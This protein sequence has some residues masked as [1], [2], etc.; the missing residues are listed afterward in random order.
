MYFDNNPDGKAQLENQRI[1]QMINDSPLPA[2]DLIKDPEARAAFEESLR[3]LAEDI[4]E[5]NPSLAHILLG[6]GVNDG[7]DPFDSVHGQN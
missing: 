4:V 3:Q 6:M 1:L 2:E 5:F 7:S